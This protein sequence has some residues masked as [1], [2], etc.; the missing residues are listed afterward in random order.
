MFWE[1]QSS[2]EWCFRIELFQKGWKRTLRS[3]SSTSDQI[4][5]DQL[6]YTIADYTFIQG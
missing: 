1:G 4:S 6:N 5:P 2:P 3:P